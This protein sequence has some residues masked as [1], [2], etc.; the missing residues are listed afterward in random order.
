MHGKGVYS[1]MSSAF[2]LLVLFGKA[3]QC[4]SFHA[5]KYFNRS[6]IQ[7]GKQVNKNVEKTEDLNLYFILSCLVKKQGMRLKINN[8]ST[9]R[10]KRQFLILKN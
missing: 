9:H 6:D 3:A 7:G 2:D 8:A 1:L 4:T 10:K 5:Q